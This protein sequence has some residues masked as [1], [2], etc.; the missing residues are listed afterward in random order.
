MKKM[1]K[2]NIGFTL[3]ELLVVVLIIGILSAVALPQYQRAVMK[4]KVATILPIL[5]GLYTAREEA[6]LRNGNYSD[7]RGFSDLTITV[8]AGYTQDAEDADCILYPSNKT[9]YCSYASYVEGNFTNAS[10]TPLVA[11][12]Y[13]L[14]GVNPEDKDNT[15][16]TH[17]G[18]GSKTCLALSTD[19]NAL[20][21]CKSMCTGDTWSFSGYTVCNLQ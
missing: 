14:K 3:I 4:S 16:F 13:Y 15:D 2:N 9:G 17:I 10:G 20:A 5:K 19:K 21:V 18:N 6:F 12:H 11:I 7:E 1:L 8:P